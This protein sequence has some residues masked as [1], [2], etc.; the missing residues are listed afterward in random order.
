MTIL[1]LIYKYS[2]KESIWMIFHTKYL[3]STV[4]EGS[5]HDA[6]K[7][8]YWLRASTLR[9]PSS[10]LHPKSLSAISM[11]YFFPTSISSFISS[12]FV[13][14]YSKSIYVCK[15]RG[16]CILE[17]IFCQSCKAVAWQGFS[18]ESV[19]SCSELKACLYCKIKKG[20]IIGNLVSIL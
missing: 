14:I 16:T 17:V 13:R 11:F 15:E 20:T 7:R 18:Y 6:V 4:W 12:V 8:S 5:C 2:F 9:M 10:G 1:E 19:E 3:L